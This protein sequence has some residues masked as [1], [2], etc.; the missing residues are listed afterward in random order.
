VPLHQVGVPPQERP[1]RDEQVTPTAA[2]EQPRA[3]A[4]GPPGPPTMAG[5]RQPD[6][7]DRELMP[8]YQDLCLFGRLGSS[9]YPIQPNIRKTIKY[10]SRRAIL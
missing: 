7:E 1:W 9:E 4:K 8:Q 6:D 5:E 10:G 2:G 3:S